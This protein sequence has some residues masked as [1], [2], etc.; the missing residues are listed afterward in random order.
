MA[1]QEW[2]FNGLGY[3]VYKRTY[4]RPLN[5][6]KTE[7]F[8]ETIERELD[9]IKRQLKLYLSPEEIE[10]YKHIRNKLK[11]S[12]AGRFMWQLGTKTVNQLG[13]SSLQNCAA[14]TVD[15]PIRPFTWAMDMLMLGCGVG[16]NIQREYVY[17]LPK[18]RKAR[19][20]RKDTKDADYIVPDS[21]EGWVRLLQHVLTAHF[22]GGGGFSYST[23]CVRGK[24]ALIKGF[25]GVASGPEEL[26]WGIEQINNVLNTRAGKKLRPIDALDIMNIIGYI[27]VAG[28]VRRS[29]QIAVGDMD[30]LQFLN[31]KRWDLGNIPNWRAMSN[32]SVVC[33]DIGALPPQFWAGYEGNGEPYGL[34]NLKLA[35]SVGRLGET[36][37][38][39]PD[40]VGFN[41][42]QPGY[43]T[44]IT[45]DGIKTFDEIN[46]GTEIWSEEGWTTVV[47]K[48]STGV[49]PVYKVKTTGGEFVG[50]LNHKVVT[51]QG[52][53]E[54]ELADKIKTIAGPCEIRPTEF[55][56]QEVMDGLF[57]GDGYFKSQAGRS[58]IYSV[59]EVGQND[60]DY[61]TS[62]LKDLFQSHFGGTTWRINTTLS[63][64]DKAHPL[65]LNSCSFLRGL[66]SANGSVI[67]QRGKTKRITYKSVDLK[68][69]NKLQQTLSTLGIR[70]YITTNKPTEVKFPNG[71]YLCKESYDL[72]ITQDA[73]V[74]K[75]KIGFIQKYKMDK[76]KDLPDLPSKDMYTKVISKEYLEDCEVFDITVDNNSHTY[77]TG[78]LSVSNCAEQSLANYET[79]C[80][81]E[82][83]L[84]RIES[85]EEFN[86][87]LRLLYKICKH[88]LALKCH[89]P[90]TQDVVNKNMR[91]GIGITG[92]LQ[93]SEKQKSWLESGY[94]M[95]RLFDEEYSKLK[96]W[97]T[98]TK[99]TTVKP[100]GTLSLLA[101]VT[102][103][104][105]PGYSQHFI[106]RLRVSAD[107]SLLPKLEAAG[108][109][110]EFARNFDGSHDVNTKVVSFPCEYP[111]GTVLAK[112]VTAVDQLNY[113]KELQT[114]W[115]DNSVS[116]TVYYKKEELPAI[117]KWL[118]QNYNEGMKTVSFLLHSD[119]GFDQAPYEEIDE[120]QYKEMLSKIKPISNLS[121]AD[122]L[123]ITEECESGACPVK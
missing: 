98:S 78:G 113:V 1:Q 79:C 24:G 15:K 50:T 108:Y 89:H 105:H 82:V 13:I 114:V 80:L 97:P 21:R 100:S 88:S 30:D 95:L 14:V 55:N 90:E 101:G 46:I 61:F 20:V 117:Q 85:Q 91:M 110:I 6:G 119:H 19:V 63:P 104:V 16:Y 68:H 38:P 70:S 48:W 42:C 109:P 56:S 111:K 27:V 86:K 74:F 81:A 118:K 76:L 2:G 103:G 73:W 23:I 57:Y 72:N 39:D 44:V 12:V 94:Q 66:Y 43:A 26:C 22:E 25:G 71:T 33:N 107:S 8:P 65:P 112:N 92:Y 62:E 123:E 41:P 60:Q 11:A 18:V 32:N 87:T 54:A 28:N 47:N 69:I 34:I 53:V 7:E 106:R 3:V 49:K 59:L 36:Q 9:G 99:L 31:A 67:S 37:Y 10:F 122:G 120:K 52:K 35:R 29:A 121:E 58:S 64:E 116:C 83:Y 51:P 115:S 17:E 4:A 45:R 77:W 102:P 5:N 84:P 93:A 40:V 96:D 75:T